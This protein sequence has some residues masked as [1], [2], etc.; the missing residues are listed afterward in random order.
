MRESHQKTIRPPNQAEIK[1]QSK[2]FMEKAGEVGGQ[3]GLHYAHL[4]R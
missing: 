4:G 2:A 3:L 1:E